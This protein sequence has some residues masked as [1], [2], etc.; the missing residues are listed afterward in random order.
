MAPDQGRSKGEIKV[1]GIGQIDLEDRAAG[2]DLFRCADPNTRLTEMP[3]E[4]GEI[5]NEIA[6][7]IGRE[8]RR[9][10]RAL[11]TSAS[12]VLVSSGPNAFTS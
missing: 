9:H 10:R 8:L 1:I 7:K 3:T 2:V 11:S 4:E 5:L 12:S 6:A